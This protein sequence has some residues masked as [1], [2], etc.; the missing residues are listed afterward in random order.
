MVKNKSAMLIGNQQD[1]AL[2]PGPKV[3]PSIIQL[4]R[5]RPSHVKSSLLWGNWASY[6][7]KNYSVSAGI[8]LGFRTS[9]CQH[10]GQLKGTA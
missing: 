4:T 5:P 1:F 8:E 9:F 3:D 6:R 7:M 10:P 2:K